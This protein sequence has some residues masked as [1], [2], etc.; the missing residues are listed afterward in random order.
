MQEAWPP[1]CDCQHCTARAAEQAR[2][3]VACRL[4]QVHQARRA[5]CHA[6]LVSGRAQHL[7]AHNRLLLQAM[8][9][10]W[11]GQIG[12]VLHAV[13]T[14]GWEWQLMAHTL[15]PSEESARSEPAPARRQCCRTR[16]QH[17]LRLKHRRSAA[18]LPPLNVELSCPAGSAQPWHATLQLHAPRRAGAPVLG[19]AH[20]NVST[21]RRLGNRQSSCCGRAGEVSGPQQASRRAGNHLPCTLL[22]PGRCACVQSHRAQTPDATRLELVIQEERKT[23]AG[24]RVRVPAAPPGR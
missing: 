15:L 5:P 21:V 4:P 10:L 1:V 17:S 12:W 24:L 9:P 23:A 11:P 8:W 18:P 13:L 14:L 19:T 16:R 7:Q 20:D 22:R 2:H 3:L 6:E